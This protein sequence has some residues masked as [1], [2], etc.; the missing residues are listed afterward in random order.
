MKQNTEIII[1]AWNTDSAAYDMLASFIV[2][3]FVVK[4]DEEPEE[5]KA[6]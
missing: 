5:V 4:A 6:V 2:K 3:H 1:E